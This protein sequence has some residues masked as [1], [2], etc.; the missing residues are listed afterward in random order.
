LF[1]DATD[2]TIIRPCD[3]KG[4]LHVHTAYGDGAHPLRRM[5]ET[6]QD[7]GL[8][9][10]GISDHFQSEI[11]PDG[12]DEA[13]E[14]TQHQEIEELRGEFPDFDILHGVE[15]DAMPDG[16]LPV[17][18]SVLEQLDYVLVSVPANDGASPEELT[19]VMLKVV[20]HPQVNIVSKPM[21]DFMLRKPPLPLDMEAVL[22][23][24][25]AH[26]TVVEIDANPHTP[27]VDHHFCRLAEEFGVKLVINTDAHRAARLVDFRT[28]VAIIQEARLC[29]ECL[30]NTRTA[31]QL[32]ALFAKKIG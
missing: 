19:A 9:Y 3:I 28:G 24:A 12:L 16:S 25:A 1:A 21:G 13:L 2:P 20:E 27:E 22:K 29:C 26:D 7:L 6:A 30:V 8:E 32:R 4:L 23:S 11:H 17:P 10:L 14:L 18:D 15:L 31:A 5:I